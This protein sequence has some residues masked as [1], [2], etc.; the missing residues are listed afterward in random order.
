MNAEFNIEISYTIEFESDGIALTV[1]GGPDSDGDVYTAKYEDLTIDL[2]D[3]CTYDDNGRMEEGDRDY[4]R[5]VAK[6]LEDVIRSINDAIR[7]SEELDA[8]PNV[9]E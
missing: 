2:L 3:M 9:I 8:E 4:L 5:G 1:F 6:K 7:I